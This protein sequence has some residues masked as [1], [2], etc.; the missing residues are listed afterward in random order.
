MFNVRKAPAWGLAALF[1]SPFAVPAHA[2]LVDPVVASRG[3]V[4]LRLS[5][6]DAKVRTMPPDVQ[7][8][9]TQ[10]PDRIARLPE[11]TSATA[12]AA[13]EAHSK[14]AWKA[15]GFYRLLNR[16]LFRAC[17]PQLRYRVLERFYRLGAPLIQRFYSS[18]ATLAD[19]ARILSGKPPVPVRKMIL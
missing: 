5:E 17:A 4:D 6:V 3:G 16:M 2:Q 14:A 13:A 10:E 11:L 9:Y 1:A 8:G 7:A 15:R 12:R 19:K 18:N